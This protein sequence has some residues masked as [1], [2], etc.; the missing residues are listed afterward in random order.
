MS[1]L[2]GIRTALLG[3]NIKRTIRKPGIANPC[4]KEYQITYGYVCC[5]QKQNGRLRKWKINSNL[6]ITE[7][8]FEN[9]R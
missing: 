3:N 2:F 9:R 1:D 5:E 6:Y 8:E 7:T 4:E